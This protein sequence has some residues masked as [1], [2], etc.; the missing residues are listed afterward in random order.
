MKNHSFGIAWLS[1]PHQTTFSFLV[2]ITLHFTATALL[3]HLQCVS[4]RR[5]TLQM[6]HRPRQHGVEQDSQTPD[7]TGGVVALPHQH[8]QHIRDTWASSVCFIQCSTHG[9]DDPHLRSHEVS[10]VA[11]SQQQT[12]VSA[13]LLGEAEVTDADGVGVSWIVHVE[14]VAGLQVPVHHL[15]EEQIVTASAP[16]NALLLRPNLC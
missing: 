12:V 3:M 6:S 9:A 1:L 16:A 15:Q 4:K 10:R 2:S 13:Q 5:E 7:V 14:D 8:L 11:G